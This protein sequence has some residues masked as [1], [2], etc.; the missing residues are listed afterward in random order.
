VRNVTFNDQIVAVDSLLRDIDGLLDR[1]R[2]ALIETI[3]I[4]RALKSIRSRVIGAV[5]SG[6]GSSEEL[7]SIASQMLGVLGLDENVVKAHGE[8]EQSQ[9]P[10]I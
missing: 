4:L 7:E 2:Q 3:K 10:Q 1:K 5:V 9:I 6:A 8:R